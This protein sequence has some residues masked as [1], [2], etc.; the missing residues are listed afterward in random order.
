MSRPFLYN[1]TIEIAFA[2]AAKPPAS[3]VQKRLE[4]IVE[5]QRHIMRDIVTR[6]RPTGFDRVLIFVAQHRDK[7][8]AAVLPLV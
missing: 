3:A 6:H 2:E 4:I 5:Q 8:L 7:N 1:Q